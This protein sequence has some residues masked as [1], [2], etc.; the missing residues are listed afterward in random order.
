MPPKKLFISYPSE[1]W[2]FAQRIAESLAPRI[3]QA[4]FID[5]R[6]I[7]QADFAESILKHL[8][9]SDAVLLVV[10]EYTFADIHRDQDWVRLEIRTALE[11]DIPIVLV[12]ENG[13]LPPG[14][15]PDDVRQVNR[16]QGVP[17]YREFFQPAI[18]LLTEFLIRIAVATPR[19]SG[20][21]A[22]AV[23][24]PVP[25]PAQMPSVEPAQ[26]TLGAAQALDEAA[27]LL[28]AG[29]FEK[30]TFLLNTVDR[31]KVR[32]VSLLVLDDLLAHAE[33]LRVEF[34]RRREAA[35]D[36]DEIVR[37]AK[38]RLTEERA[39]AAFATWCESYP[40]LIAEM[41][42]S[43]L[44]D[45]FA[46]PPPPEL[47]A[48]LKALLPAPF[49]M[50]PIPAGKV[51][52]ET[53][54]TFDVPAFSIA[55]YPVTNAHY[56]PFV[57]G[58]GYSEQRWWTRDG[59]AARQAGG[60]TQPR[61]WDDAKWNGDDDPVVGVSW[62]EAVAYCRWLSA[63]TGGQ[64]ALPTEQMWQRAAQGDKGWKYPWGNEWDG[65]RC[66]N[67]VGQYNS[68]RTTPVT[69]YAGKD[70][71]DSPFGVSDMAGNVWEWCI[72]DY[73]TGDQDVNNR[74]AYRVLRGGAWNDDVADLFAAANRYG[75]SPVVRVNYF[76]FRFALL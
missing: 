56:R 50:I 38:R 24:S 40:D 61:Y 67:S 35:L 76:G 22:P 29:D 18:D 13:L 31:A 43:G 52:L 62:Y 3:D 12:R 33:T 57:S 4:I 34:V 74:A 51:T 15:L 64:I 59:W 58:G 46:P 73:N 47:I 63:Q 72:T 19:S 53:G 70:K 44:R 30:A 42:T 69:Q 27:N 60:W 7:D 28:E 39:R 10:T 11:N 45:R 25:P 49:E 48:R 23:I 20:A 1:S 55:R 16:S 71:G 75:L 26:R 2:N 6:S 17:F 36:Y 5:Y 68:D 65:A 66:N 54:K 21:S 14:D 8:G 41:D 37:W 9:E 32:Q